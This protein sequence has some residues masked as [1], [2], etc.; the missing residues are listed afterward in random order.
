MV[1]FNLA[2][3]LAAEGLEQYVFCRNPGDDLQ[4]ALEAA[5]IPVIT[6]RR[7]VGMAGIFGTA[8]KVA[9]LVQREGIDLVHAHMADAALIA[10][11]ASRRTGRPF[12]ITH[13]GHEIVPACGFPCEPIFSVLLRRAASRTCFNVGVAESVVEVILRRLRAERDRTGLIVNGVFAP[14][15]RQRETPARDAP[16][17]VVVGRLIEL[18]GQQQLIRALPR[19]REFYPGCRLWLVGEGPERA[20][21]QALAESLEVADSVDFHGNVDNVPDYLQ[22]ADVYVSSSHHEG[23]PVATLEAMAWQL[24]VVVSDVVGNNRVVQQDENGLL[25]PLDDIDALT[26]AIR[27]VI[28]KPD[29]TARRVERAYRMVCD[30]YSIDAS[31][32]A[33]R[34]LYERCLAG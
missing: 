14:D 15:W 18:K 19:L 31:A 16:V 30:E 25:Y 9:D 23:I 7:Y 24:P 1:V 28:D 6:P 26:R 27:L 21:L 3:K 11:L 33:Y 5:G 2:R 32:K 4:A 8:R 17:L 34:A 22:R 10:G 29:A 12:V 13:H 20:G